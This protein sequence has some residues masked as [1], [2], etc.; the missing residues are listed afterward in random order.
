MY[1]SKGGRVTLIKSSLANLPMYFMSL[2]PL[3]ASI[4]N[5]I[6]KLQ[7]DF[8][9]DGQGEEFKYHLDS[10]SKVC[11]P[12]S[13][14]GLGIQNLLVDYRQY[15]ECCCVEDSTYMPFMVFMEGR[16]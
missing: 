5:H 2:F 13:G 4:T 16:E 14:K 12:L 8:L 9:W 6:E 7:H 10:W 11:S 1:L 3:P 15:A